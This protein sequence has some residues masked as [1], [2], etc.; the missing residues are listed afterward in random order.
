MEEI[1]IDIYLAGNT[2]IHQEKGLVAQG[3]TNRLLS[4]WEYRKKTNESFEFWKDQV[5][6]GNGKLFLD[7]GAYS[8]MRQGKEVDIDALIEFIKQHE[9]GLTVYAALDVID[10]CPEDTM[11]NLKY[12]EEKGVKPMPVW[13]G[14]EDWKYLDYYCDRYEYIALGGVAGLIVNKNNIMNLMDHV[15]KRH[16]NNKFHAFGIT[17]LSVLKEFPFYSADSTS[18]LMCG[19]MGSIMTPYGNIYISGKGTKDPSHYDYKSPAE[20]EV[21]L[22]YIESKG[23]TLEQVRD[24]YNYRLLLNAQFIKDFQD[25]YEPKSQRVTKRHLF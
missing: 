19:A 15:F 8:A 2:K 3:N 11:K 5:R 12:M 18:W 13:H 14:G 7:C 21:I 1:K 17:M 16:P 24:D 22:N 4:F 25:S 20:R 10:G 9:D 6:S 23:F